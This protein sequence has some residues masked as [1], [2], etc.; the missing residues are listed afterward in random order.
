[1]TKALFDLS[2]VL[3]HPSDIH[4]KLEN[5]EKE[6]KNKYEV[7]QKKFNGKMSQT[8]A[9]VKKTNTQYLLL[10]EKVATFNDFKNK[11][12]ALLN[13]F[14][15]LIKNYKMVK[16][17]CLAH[18]RFI[19]I[20]EFYNNFQSNDELPDKD[21]LEK[22]H[23]YIFRKEEFLCELEQYNIE[24]PGE[25]INKIEDVIQEIKKDSIN[26]TL[27][28]LEIVK[29][30]KNNFE[31]IPTINKIVEKEENRDIL[32][33][34]ATE[35]E[36]G[37]DLVLFQIS[38]MYPKYITRKPKNLKEKTI[39]ILEG[40]IKEKF[41][42]SKEDFI[43]HLDVVLDELD[44]FNEKI[45]LYFFT[46]A[47]IL[48]CYHKNLKTAIKK[49]I[50]LMDAGEIL[51][52][53]EFKTNYYAAIE[54]KYNKIAESL[55]ERLIDN[56]NELLEKYAHTAANKLNS[57]IETITKTEIE[58]FNTR[59]GELNKDEEEKLIST[60]FIN[61]LQMIKVQLEP[62]A[63][64]KKV[65]LYITKTVKEYCQIFQSKICSAI[66]KDFEPSCK[67]KSKPGFEDYCIV[68]GN[69]GL[70][71]TQYITSLPQCQSDEVRELGNIFISILKTCN[72]FLSKFVI[73]IC[74]PAYSNFFT[75]KWEQNF[76]VLVVTLE[77][78]LQDYQT[79][80]ADFTFLTFCHELCESLVETYL[81]RIKHKQS[82]FEKNTGSLLRSNIKKIIALFEKFINETD[83]KDLF[84]PLEKTANLIDSTNSDLFLLELKSLLLIKDDINIKTI[85]KIVEKKQNV[86][87][88]CK[89][90]ILEKIEKVYES[91]E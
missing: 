55:G 49:H 71:L 29:D 10:N 86:D 30:Y 43:L 54:T 7:F 18:Q 16:T 79:A 21:D 23:G 4:T 26:F 42:V 1:M 17:V 66:E 25:D 40:S 63:F 48:D 80:M 34:K 52:L 13:D 70:K 37:K 76:D 51:K 8:Y 61:L 22:Y 31:L 44:F 77:D 47:Q 62:I 46:F 9:K 69:S 82:T 3:R 60:G 45:E 64:N 14:T 5:L 11:N 84:L 81:K 73:F 87:S 67:G 41:L 20:K 2:E 78:F 39:Q 33:I 36:N 38:K 58:K 90:E 68:F 56:E 24:M 15:F 83:L 85:E 12:I 32:T 6:C 50:D 91:K 59:D 72:H 35:G 88:K 57:W 75:S 28:F 19:K 89:K 53:I 74:K 27:F 65:F